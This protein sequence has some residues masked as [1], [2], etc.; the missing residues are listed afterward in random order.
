MVCDLLR[1]ELS[2]RG[3]L[4]SAVLSGSD[5]LDKLTTED[6]EVVLL[7]IR[8]SGMSGI[9]VLREVW[10]THSNTATIMITAVNDVSEDDQSG[11]VVMK[12]ALY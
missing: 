1:D 4:C 2:E 6:F 9:E 5:A 7:D 11:A 8:L 12:Q 3:Y 10:L